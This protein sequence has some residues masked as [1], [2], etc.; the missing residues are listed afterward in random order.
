MGSPRSRVACGI[1]IAF[2]L[3]FATPVAADP[4]QGIGQPTIARPTVPPAVAAAAPEFRGGAEASSSDDG[5]ELTL[6]GGT[7]RDDPISINSEEL[8]VL[9]LEGGRRLVFSRNVE[10]LQGEVTL[11]ADRLEALYPPGASQPAELLASGHVRVSQGDRRARCDEAV[12]HRSTHTIVCRGEAEV[13]QGCDRMRGAEIE[14]DLD[15][16]RVRVMGAAFVEIRPEDGDGSE[17]PAAD[18]LGR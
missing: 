5:S 6:L 18:G 13:L 12:Y 9:Q 8:E 4:E 15:T 10:V 2:V 17:C 11:N 1:G 16:D 3:E 14:F 7:R